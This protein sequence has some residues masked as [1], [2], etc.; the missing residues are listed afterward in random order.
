VREYEIWNIHRFFLV[1]ASTVLTTLVFCLLSV[2]SSQS[3][4]A[5][6]E[7]ADLDQHLPFFDA[8]NNRFKDEKGLLD[9]GFDVALG[10]TMDSG[11]IAVGGLQ[12]ATPWGS[13]D[14]SAD[15][16]R[17]GPE[18]VVAR[19]DAKG[20]WAAFP[21]HQWDVSGGDRGYSTSQFE[22]FAGVF[23]PNA[24]TLYTDSKWFY[25]WKENQATITINLTLRKVV[26]FG[27]LPIKLELAADYFIEQDDRFGQDWAVTLNFSPVVP[28]FIYDLL[29]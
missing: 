28:N 19:I 15:Q 8:A 2:T 5:E 21:A 27:K 1:P 12:G 3:Q 4:A 25:D 24:W 26:G 11:F 23:L 9:P 29:H 14:L 20:F 7:G 16:W 6:G 10:K 17:L 13:D 22:W 18:F